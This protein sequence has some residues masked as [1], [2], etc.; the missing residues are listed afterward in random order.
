MFVLG[1]ALGTWGDCARLFLG[2]GIY[3]PIGSVLLDF[4][5]LEVSSYSDL[6]IDG[7]KC[8]CR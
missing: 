3:P 6:G 4:M 7:M 2:E 5:R 8:S 1:R